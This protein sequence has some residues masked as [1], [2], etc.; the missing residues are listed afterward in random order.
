MS[1]SSEDDDVFVMGPVAASSDPI[2]IA[3][4]T[5]QAKDVVLAT[6]SVFLR[7]EAQLLVPSYHAEPTRNQPISCSALSAWNG[8]G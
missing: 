8:F 2:P 6:Q 4:P 3:R 5:L 7:E 1:I